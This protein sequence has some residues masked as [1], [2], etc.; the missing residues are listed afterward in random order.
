MLLDLRVPIPAP[1]T[2]ERRYERLPLTDYPQD[3][4]RKY[5]YATSSQERTR[6]C[7]ELAAP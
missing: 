4:E 5:W 7:E 2:P 1:G 6:R 3:V